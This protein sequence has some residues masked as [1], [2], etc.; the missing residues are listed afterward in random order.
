MMRMKAKI[1]VATVSG[2]AYYLLVTELN[3]K[4]Q[5]FLSLTPWD[6][7]PLNIEVVITT[8]KEQTLVN[9]PNILVYKEGDDPSKIVA[10]AVRLSKGKQRYEKVV[11]GIDPGKTFGLAIL[12]DGH[13]IETLNCSSQE[14]TVQ[15]ILDA[16]NKTPAVQTTVKVGNGPPSYTNVLLHSLD[17]NLPPDVKIEIV[18]EAGTTRVVD[19]AKHR[20]EIKDMMSAMRIAKRN[21]QTFSRG[22]KE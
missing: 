13:V 3:K 20:R 18:S 21:G 14:E 16:I 6:Q 15:A 2:K 7:I 5:Q 1:A 17:E 12:G 10:E 9:H 4:K 11:I 22:K 19:E 8:E